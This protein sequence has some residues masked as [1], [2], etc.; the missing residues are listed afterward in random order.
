MSESSEKAVSIKIINPRWCSRA[1]LEADPGSPG[2][3]AIFSQSHKLAGR[4][5]KLG[6]GSLGGRICT[7]TVIHESSPFPPPCPCPQYL[8]CVWLGCNILPSCVVGTTIL[9]PKGKQRVSVDKEE[10]IKKLEVT[11]FPFSTSLI[12][13]PAS[14]CSGVLLVWGMFYIVPHSLLWSST[15]LG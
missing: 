13:A 7:S 5:Y 12:P 10:T 9:I 11:T 2:P 3:V 6:L 4:V 8:P 14:V 15:E 1:G